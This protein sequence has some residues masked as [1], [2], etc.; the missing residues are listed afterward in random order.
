MNYPD[1]RWVKLYTR[2]TVNRKLLCWQGKAFLGVLM[3]YVDRAGRLDAEGD[4]V[5]GVAALTEMPA[6]FVRAALYG[7]DS[8]DGLTTRGTVTVRDGVVTLPNWREAQ[9]AHLSNK[10][11]QSRHRERNAAL[12][13]RN[14]ALR[15]SNGNPTPVTPPLVCSPLVSSEPSESS[16]DRTDDL[17]VSPA[18]AEPAPAH[19]HGKVKRSKPQPRPDEP[20]LPGTQARSVYDAIIADPVLRPITGNPGDW[21]SRATDPAT[22]PGVDV[23]AE[24]KRAGMWAAEHPG[25]HTDG[26]RY[27]ANWLQRKA[28]EVA[29]Q[30]RPAAPAPR[31]PLPVRA[32]PLPPAPVRLASLDE[33]AAEA[34]QA[35]GMA[36]GV[37]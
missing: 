15:N 4:V 36:G 21:S 37:Q 16:G 10:A 3:C 8:G 12:P 35:R 24:V 23:L 33:I 17:K 20:P 18:P 14:G 34:R 19:G 27:L 2:Q 5:E 26:R 13:D 22:Y 31:S 30:P 7:T 29:R 6:E 28:D 25:K 9:E 32:T 1:E 11:R